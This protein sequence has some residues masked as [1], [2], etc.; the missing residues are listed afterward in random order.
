M[1]ARCSIL[2]VLTSIRL[3]GD[4]NTEI[5]KWVKHPLFATQGTLIFFR[6]IN[7]LCF[8]LPRQEAQSS[9]V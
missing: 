7:V 5:E 9:K 6:V 2:M 3:R 8:F 4:E 1:A